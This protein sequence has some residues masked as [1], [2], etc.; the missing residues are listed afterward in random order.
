MSFKTHVFNSYAH[1][2]KLEA[3]GPGWVTR[4]HEVLEPLRTSRLNRTKA[5]IWRDKRLSDND[6]CDPVIM[7][8]LPDAAVFVAV[9]SDNCVYADWCRREAQ[10]FCDI[11]ARGVGLA[12]S[13]KQRDASAPGAV[14]PAIAAADPKKPTVYLAQCGD[15]RQGDRQSLRSE[16][17]QR[18]DYKSE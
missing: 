7:K 4:F 8:H 2:N 13:D 3:G 10:A 6:D 1:A 9:L 16:H 12:P 15:D 17:A 11:A 5:T 14:L 18:G